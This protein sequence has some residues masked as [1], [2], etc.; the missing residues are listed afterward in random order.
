MNKKIS[1]AS[2]I[3]P[4]PKQLKNHEVTKPELVRLVSNM[5]YGAGLEVNEKQLAKQK[6]N[7]LLTVV[8]GMASYISRASLTTALGKSFGGSRDFYTEFG[9][10]KDLDFSDYLNVYERNG[11]GGRIVDLKADKSWMKFFVLH[12]GKSKEDYEDGTPF[13]KAWLDLID[14]D[15]INMPAAFNELDKAL[16]ISRFSIMVMGVKGSTDYA[17]PLEKGANKLEFIRVLDEGQVTMFTSPVTDVFNPR[18]GL[19]EIYHCKFEETGTAVPVHWTRVIHFKAGRGRSNIYGI[20]GLQRSMNNLLDLEKV[21]GSSSEA[22]WQHI[23]RITVLEGRDGYE[24]PA[25]GT[26]E[27]TK[28]QSDLE[29]FEHKM[30]L[31]LRIKN[32]DAK[33]LGSEAVDGKNQHDLLISEIAGTEGIPQRVLIGSERG[34]LASSQDIL[35]LDTMIEG[36]QVTVCEPWVKQVVRY[37]Y[38]WGFI[39]APSTGKFSVE[40]NPLSQMT[41]TEKVELGQ[42][43]L[44]LLDKATEGN[45]QTQADA[46]NGI[47]EES[48][49]GYKMTPIEDVEEN[50]G[51]GEGEEPGSESDLGAG[52][53]DETS[54]LKVLA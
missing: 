39:P 24:L 33:Q 44:D 14:S 8:N 28:M 20:P 18:F 4:E 5:A 31:V 46:V 38:T 32:A 15:T 30:R 19:P 13:L 25:E 7:D 10:K 11:I 29:D 53:E 6:K 49:D 37:L 12:D 22:F 45:L 41:P 35:N 16:G 36:R 54:A 1:A 23:R 40:W 21:T 27:Y 48:L 43:K 2:R 3:M 9:W 26:P 50:T 47:L 51:E 42:K 34:E 52:L 17:K